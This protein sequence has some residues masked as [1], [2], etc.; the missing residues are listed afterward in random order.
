V[1]EG[2]GGPLS[3]NATGALFPAFWRFASA[4][5]LMQEFCLREKKRERKERR[6]IIGAISSVGSVRK[7]ASWFD[8]AAEEIPVLEETQTSPEVSADRR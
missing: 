5:I 8:D 2:G 4:A 1:G 6:R 3:G 7:I